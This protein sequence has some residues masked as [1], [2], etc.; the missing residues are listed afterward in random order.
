MPTVLSACL[1]ILLKNFFLMPWRWELSIAG[2]RPLKAL[3]RIHLLGIRATA[4][5]QASAPFTSSIALAT[6]RKLQA[7]HS[8]QLLAPARRAQAG[9]AEAFPAEADSPVEALAAG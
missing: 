5:V 9:A 1:R 6:W 2:P 8:S 7:Q 4:Q 3:S